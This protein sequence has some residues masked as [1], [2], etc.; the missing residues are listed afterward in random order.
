MHSRRRP[1]RGHGLS[2]VALLML[3][4][5]GFLHFPGSFP[6]AGWLCAAASGSHQRGSAIGRLN[7][8]RFS[9][10]TLPGYG[11]P[12]TH[13]AL[14]TVIS[15]RLDRGLRSPV[16]MAP[17]PVQSKW[18]TTHPVLLA[19]SHNRGSYS[20]VW[21]GSAKGITRFEHIR[22]L[23]AVVFHLRAFDRRVP[24]PF[25]RGN[26]IPWSGIISD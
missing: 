18:A 25:A 8:T 3:V 16:Q 23:A 14:E 7:P 12:A 9:T 19:S 11:L 26:W 22:R 15:S 24:L 1:R 20:A 21:A 6:F 4:P 5:P 2:P 13:P 17:T 10:P